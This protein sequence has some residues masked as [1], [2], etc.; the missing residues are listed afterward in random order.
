MAKYSKEF[1]IKLVLEIRDGQPL[2][3]V[4]RKYGVSNGTIQNWWN[5]YRAGGIKQLVSTNEGYTQEIKLRAIEYRWA[6]SLSY[7][8][9]AA[10]L[11]IPYHATLRK[12]ERRYLER[13]MDGLQD[14]GKGRHPKMPKKEAKTKISSTREQE[15]EAENAQLRMENAYLKKLN[16]LVAERE[17]SVKKTK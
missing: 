10:D 2:R 16:A 3:A 4:A 15:L 8:Q 7:S 17:K 9:A 14:T 12:W 13:G 6:N 5:R 1:R 11:G